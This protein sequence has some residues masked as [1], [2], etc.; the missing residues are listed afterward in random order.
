MNQKNTYIHGWFSAQLK[1]LGR[2]VSAVLM[3]IIA[4]GT[5]DASTWK[6]TALVNTEAF[7]IIDDTDTS[8]NVVL[9]FGDTLAKTLIYNRTLTR[10][11]FND[12]VY[13]NGNIGTSG[14][15]SGASLFGLGLGSCS[16][17]T[18]SKL[19]YDSA[20]GRFSC[21]TDQTGGGG[22]A[23]STGNV[24]T[25]GGQKYVS[26]QGDT[27]TGALTVN[28]SG[29]SPGTLGVKVVNTLSG[30]ILHAEKNLTSS[31]TILSF[32]TILTKA[33]LVTSSYGHAFLS[34]ALM[35]E[36]SGW[37]DMI[38]IQSGNLGTNGIT[39]L[40]NGGN[41]TNIGSVE[42]GEMHVRVGG[43]FTNRIN[44]ASG[45]GPQKI[46][47]GDLNGDG[48]ADVAVAVGGAVSVLINNGTGGL[49][50]KVEYG[51]FVSATDIALSDVSGDGKLDIIIANA[52]GKMSVFLNKGN[53]TFKT[54]VDYSA[55]GT[56]SR[57]AV[58]DINGDGRPDVVISD[59]FP[60]VAIG[61]FLNM[62]NGRFGNEITYEADTQV[63]EIA[64]GDFNGD[65]R[66][67]VVTTNSDSI[68]N[69]SIF[70]NR[71]DGTFASRVDSSL[72]GNAHG[73]VVGDFNSDTKLDIAV[74]AGGASIL[75]G[76]GDGTFAAAVS[77]T[78]GTAPY[79]ISA[80]DL[81][82]DGKL[83]IMTTNGGT[84]TFSVLLNK[85]NGAFAA[86]TDYTMGTTPRGIANGDFN[87]DGK[88]DIVVVNNG[89][90]SISTYFN[91]TQSLLYASSGT[92][93]TVGIGTSTPGS[94]LSVSGSVIIG[95][96]IANKAAKTGVNLEIIGTLS[97]SKLKL[98][99]LTTS[100]G[101]LFNS[102]SLVQTTA[103]GFSGQL[104]ISRGTGTP[105]WKS[106][107]GSMVWYIGGTTAVGGTQGPQVVLPF[108]FR[109]TDVFMVATGAPTGSALIVDLKQNGTTI[110]SVKPQINAGATTGGSSAV[111]STSI[112]NQGAILTLDVTQVG[113]TFAGSGLTV[114]LNGSRRY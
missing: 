110:F 70:M 88:V 32:G 2:V 14:T 96:N 113:S 5:V 10:F 58:G 93:G 94:K 80:G 87:G 24:L 21:G 9:K 56:T 112:I 63:E 59:P 71:G 68:N 82:G 3:V 54:N 61:V 72:G 55:T 6:P 73:V 17:A 18:T 4:T 27:M 53:G 44:Y 46:A 19:L 74:A 66:A 42:S 76:N 79:D 101:I 34:G 77:Y 57:V 114:L 102:G 95:N 91:S 40:T 104:L 48:K 85:G 105:E 50:A 33:A 51:S 75:M 29:G 36:L 16:N 41:L 81:N 67:D 60:G 103:K 69:L 15:L 37:N 30:A 22:S 100:G 62:G 90:N 106:P 108:G 78:T 13:V 52:F 20:T 45:T 12:T 38:N 26:K 8:T 65:G 11:E 7:Q 47:I 99:N 109:P 84:S 97:G 89:N 83:D 107:T 35:N 23:F 39:R 98:S 64:L 92:G 49:A 28:V 111:L 1:Q 43:T 25:I 86:K 31:G